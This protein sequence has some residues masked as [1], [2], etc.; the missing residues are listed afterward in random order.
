MFDKQGGSATASFHHDDPVG[1]MHD[2]GN[3]I[4]IATSAVRIMAAHEEIAA[5]SELSTVVSHAAS[6]LE[7]AGRLIRRSN[8]FEEDPSPEA[9]SL[10]SCIAQFSP[11]LRYVVG[12]DVRIKL[13]IGMVPKVQC[14]SVGLQNALLNLALNARDAMPGGGTLTLSAMVAEGP[15]AAEVEIVVR[16]TGIGMTPEILAR[17]TEPYFTT[18]AAASGHGVGLSGVKSFIESIGG[19]LSIA[20]QPYAGTSVTLRLPVA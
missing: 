17:A 15:E 10:E 13:L 12:P 19:R 1:L 6:S 9:V 16:D 5:S 18:K 2:L 3:Y 7:G 4:Q 8:P 11:L 20:S 14:T